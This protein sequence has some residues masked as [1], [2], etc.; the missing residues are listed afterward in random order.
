MIAPPP[1][2]LPSVIESS[3]APYA[4]DDVWSGSA[5]KSSIPLDSRDGAIVKPE[6]A[7]TGA[8]DVGCS[9]DDDERRNDDVENDA[10]DV[11]ST[12]GDGPNAVEYD[13]ISGKP[14][15][16]DDDGGDDDTMGATDV[17]VVDASTVSVGDATGAIDDAA[18]ATVDSAA[19]SIGAATSVVVGTVVVVV[20]STILT[21][22]T[23]VVAIV[24]AIVDSLIA[25]FSLSSS[26]VVSFVSFV[27]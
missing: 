27:T 24:G 1:P 14:T 20:A 10:D 2:M 15:S 7:C 22:G 4:D 12:G 26:F 19:L 16:N 23:V 3:R 8:I 18:G 5:L 25:C 9:V 17:S 11:D 13:W 21:V 6:L